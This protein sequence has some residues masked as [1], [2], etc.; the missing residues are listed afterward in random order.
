MIYLGYRYSI[1][2]VIDK[3]A[4]LSTANNSQSPDGMVDKHTSQ[5]NG[6]PWALS[7]PSLLS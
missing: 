6:K 4:D 7:A 5:G 2:T 3:V 1:D